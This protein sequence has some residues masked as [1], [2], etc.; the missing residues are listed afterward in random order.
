MCF[1]LLAQCLT[2]C[3]TAKLKRRKIMVILGSILGFV[4]LFT[5]LQAIDA[6]T[7]M[8]AAPSNIWFA[9]IAMFVILGAGILTQ[10][11]QLI[12]HHT[13]T[14]Q[15]T[16]SLLFCP[17]LIRDIILSLIGLSGLPVILSYWNKL[18]DDLIY[19]KYLKQRWVQTL[20]ESF[21]MCALLLPVQFLNGENAFFR[22][23]EILLSILVSMISFSSAVSRYWFWQLKN[24]R[25][26]GIANIS[27][28]VNTVNNGHIEDNNGMTNIKDS[29]NMNGNENRK[30]KKQKKTNHTVEINGV[31]IINDHFFEHLVWYLMS[32]IYLKSFF[33]SYMYFWCIY[34]IVYMLNIEDYVYS[35]HYD[36]TNLFDDFGLTLLFHI[37]C[38]FI[39]TIYLNRKAQGTMDSIFIKI[40]NLASTIIIKDKHNQHQDNPSELGLQ[41]TVASLSVSSTSPATSPRQAQLQSQSGKR[42]D[43][44]HN[45]ETEIQ[46]TINNHEL[47]IREDTGLLCEWRCC[48]NCCNGC[49]KCCN[50]SCCDRCRLQCLT[51][52]C[53]E[54][55]IIIL[56][57]IYN[58]MIEMLM[59]GVISNLSDK[60]K[61]DD[62]FINTIEIV[63][64]GNNNLNDKVLSS[65]S[66]SSLSIDV[67]EELI[68]VMVVDGMMNVF[69]V[70]LWISVL[71]SLL[72]QLPFIAYVLI[73]VYVV[74]PCIVCC[75]SLLRMVAT[76][77]NSR[78]CSC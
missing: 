78:C 53:I 33:Q 21:P 65:S 23:P 48:N 69:L 13:F 6:I 28:H 76:I 77:T 64:S 61:T 73:V 32:D 3:G 44:T 34:F 54:S 63:D 49:C 12:K 39:N 18:D 67:K 36:T 35:H 50:C 71:G 8:N 22:S 1:R 46:T 38:V 72:G 40:D 24:L 59:T 14:Y 58:V 17:I 62:N 51:L 16:T 75:V 31:F 25:T 29:G 60:S 55:N 30:R 37:I 68:S 27:T 9:L 52:C 10:T 11:Y 70:M 57:R 7:R 45:T 15:N 26:I 5:D 47:K 2:C 19:A 74:I 4:D 20:S 41:Q 56:L 43:N 66:S 42:F